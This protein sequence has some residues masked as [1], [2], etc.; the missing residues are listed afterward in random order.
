MPVGCNDLGLIILLALNF[1][2]S[3]PVKEVLP[4]VYPF[5]TV[6]TEPLIEQLGEA[7]IFEIDVHDVEE[8]NV[9]DEG[10]VT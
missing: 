7:P 6:I 5:E 2:A 4:E 10:K 9:I 1:R 8:G 3:D